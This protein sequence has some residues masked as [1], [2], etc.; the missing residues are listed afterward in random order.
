MLLPL[1]R[2]FGCTLLLAGVSCMVGTA[3][4][5]PRNADRAGGS[6]LLVGR[7]FFV[8]VSALLAAF[9]FLS[10]LLGH[11]RLALAFVFVA[12][13]GTLILRRRSLA[14]AGSRKGLLLATATFLALVAVFW[15]TTLTLWM[16]WGMA[17]DQSRTELRHLGSIHSLRYANYATFIAEHD[18]VPYVPQNMGQSLLASIHLLLGM[19]YPLAAL[20]SWIPVALAALTLLLFGTLRVQGLSP[21][22]SAAGTFFVLSCNV[23]LSANHVLVLDNGSPLAFVGYTDLVLA[24]GTWLVFV[25]WLEQASSEG[26]GGPWSL[27]LPGLFVCTW[28]WHA[29]QNLVAA[30]AAAA[31]AA[32]AGRGASF[33]RRGMLPAVVFLA[34][35]LLGATQIGPFLPPALREGSRHDGRAPGI[36]R[37]VATL[38]VVRDERL[39]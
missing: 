23:S 2:V 21:A 33:Q 39:V 36:R 4:M 24:I 31:G 38:R 35:G 34:A 25:A 1:G 32:W 30:G 13:V 12:V 18:R 27:L 6:A 28:C 19:P 10:H 11:A 8:G 26:L 5:P 14:D 7:G 9:V 17:S 3:L 16:Q 29:P 22:M 15:V 37:E 20:S